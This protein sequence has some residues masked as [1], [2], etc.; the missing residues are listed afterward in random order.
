MNWRK[1][2]AVGTALTAVG[3]FVPTPV[4]QKCVAVAAN[5]LD[6]AEDKDLEY[7]DVLYRTASRLEEVKED[8]GTSA[9]EEVEYVQIRGLKSSAKG[10]IVIP[11]EIDGVNISSAKSGS[12]PVKLSGEYSKR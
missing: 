7:G 5:I 8:D 4:M 12:V 9:Y 6:G 10:D 2:I 11:D 1:L 3:A